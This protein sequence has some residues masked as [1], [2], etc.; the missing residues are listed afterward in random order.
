[1]RMYQVE[2]DEEVFQ[3]IKDHA[4]PLMDTFNSTLR[5]LLPLPEGRSHVKSS[6]KTEEIKPDDAN[7]LPSL[8]KRLPKGLRYILEVVHLVQNGY[9]RTSATRRVAR[10]HNVFPQTIIDKYTRQ[11]KLTASGFDR[12]LDQ[13]NLVE[14]QRALVSKFPK[15]NQIIDEVLVNA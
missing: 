10:N 14:L 12:L 15:Y 11:I 6:G 13:V 9:S 4:E 3:F 1:M 7:F 2:V 5:R 8:P